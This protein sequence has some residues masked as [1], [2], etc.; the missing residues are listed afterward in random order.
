MSIISICKA[1]FTDGSCTESYD[2][3]VRPDLSF[4][5]L[6]YF[7]KIARTVAEQSKDPSTK[8]GAVIVSPDKQIISTG[9]N[10][11]PVGVEDNKD[12]Y[13]DRP[14]KLKMVVHAEANA[15]CQAAKHGHCID[16]CYIFCTL[17]PCIS[18]AKLIIQSGIKHVF[19]PKYVPTLLPTVAVP[20]VSFDLL[21][22]IVPAFCD[23]INRSQVSFIKKCLA[24]NAMH[25]DSSEH[26]TRHTTI[27]MPQD[28]LQTLAS[29]AIDETCYGLSKAASNKLCDINEQYRTNTPRYDVGVLYN[30]LV[31]QL[32]AWDEQKLTDVGKCC[33]D[34]WRDKI[35]DSIDLL[36]EAGV[37]AWQLNE[38]ES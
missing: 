36:N 30:S 11:F 19:F 21:N 15:I 5:W 32:K 8:V 26:D 35:K 1:G 20:M 16:G 27:T 33:E 38:E 13:E 23:S 3:A 25:I 4:R 34:E 17:V 10:G 12:R 28:L 6:D 31:T 29:T 37:H 14:T 18:C 24:H 2:P 9:Y 22:D 7:L